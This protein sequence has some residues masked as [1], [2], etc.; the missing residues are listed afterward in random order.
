MAR[1]RL[2]TLILSCLPALAAA[3]NTIDP[4]SPT[5]LTLVD[6]TPQVLAVLVTSQGTPVPFPPVQWAV[7][8]ASGASAS[9]QPV[10]SPQEQQGYSLV[11]ATVAGAKGS[12]QITATVPGLP[13]VV[14]QVTNAGG[15]VRSLAVIDGSHQ[16]TVVN[17]PFAD[18]IVVEARDF[19]GDPV[20]GVPITFAGATTGAS[21][22]FGGAVTTDALGRA[23]AAAT[24]NGTAG[25]HTA[26]AS[27]P[28]PGGG[29]VGSPGIRLS[30]LT[31]A[32]GGMSNP[33]GSG[34]TLVIGGN[35]ASLSVRVTDANG[36][37][38]TGV[39]VRFAGPSTGAGLGTVSGTTSSP[40]FEFPGGGRVFTVNGTATVSVRA[41]ATPGAYDVVGSVAGVPSTMRFALTN[42][43]PA[44]G[45]LQPNGRPE[46]LMAGAEAP[47]GGRFQPF[48]FRVVDTQNHPM[49]G[50]PVTM[51]AP[52]TEPTILLDDTVV[53]TDATG[54]ARTAGTASST[55][56]FYW[57]QATA[58]GAPAPVSMLMLN[59]PPGYRPGDQLADAAAVDDTGTART[60]RGLLTPG[61]FLILDVC[62]NWCSACAL[63]APQIPST[64][65]ALAAQGIDVDLVPVLREGPSPGTASTQTDA[66]AWRQAFALPG[67]ALHASGDLRSPLAR[68]ADL[69]AGALSPAYPTYLLV[70]PDGTILDRHVGALDGAAMTAFVQAH[71]TSAVSI[72]STSVSESGG[73]ATVTLTRTPV[74]G[75][76]TVAFATAPGSASAADFVATQGTVTFAAGQSTTT[77]DIPI[78]DDAID[79]PAEQF[80][81]SLTAVQNATV[82]QGTAI[83]TIV[84]DDPPPVLTIADQRF[85]E[86]TG[87]A[88]PARVLVTMDRPSSTPVIVSYAL[89]AGTA[90]AADVSLT[91]GTVTL[92][93]G[94][95]AQSIALAIVPDKV[96]ENKETFTLRI[97]SATNAKVPVTDAILTIVDDD[98]DTAPPVFAAVS[99]VIVEVKMASTGVTIVPFSTPAAKD[100]RDGAVPVVCTP[101]SGAK[102][103]YGAWP[104]TCT[105]EDRAGNLATTRFNAIVRPPTVA[106]ALFDPRDRTTPITTADA[107]APVLVHVNAGAFLPRTRITLGFVDVSGRRF[108]LER[109]RTDANGGLDVVIRIPRRAAE[110]PGQVLAEGTNAGGEY[111]RG[112]FL[113]VT[114][115][116]RP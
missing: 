25:L 84:D 70:G 9:I 93:P 72:G 46:A 18:P 6:G 77:I 16:S 35:A 86:G 20:A 26:F 116:N 21:A 28:F 48:G 54:F 11:Q 98:I 74:A 76:A 81:V 33:N 27:T 61:R 114:G 100:G 47:P 64:L 60:L 30:N 67:I 75:T 19:A 37:P 109:G 1:T 105:A 22:T 103:G 96:I 45:A 78:T 110:G 53:V 41:N 89:I 55:S 90:T 39:A 71:V 12:Y 31:T 52:L 87:T 44:I 43:A 82:T 7:V 85:I 10:S 3:Q 63:V 51:T 79:E 80:T 102:L 57:L 99:D 94:E 23:S 101:G 95:I 106:G 34:Q 58:P 38:L 36:S 112:W 83:V 42:T 14:F 49:A 66:V 73:L 107:E 5:T 113:T 115:C 104:I 2:L 40:A 97:T 88:I 92:R 13:P 4:A 29:T 108:E 59:L 17:T 8:P 62:A 111:D 32:P 68:A 91:A 24:A 56:G 69:I 50:V 65:A 15:V